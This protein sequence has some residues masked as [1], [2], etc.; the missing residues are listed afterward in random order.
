MFN[1]HQSNFLHDEPQQKVNKVFLGKYLEIERPCLFYFCMDVARKLPD[2]KL[3][4]FFISP[5]GQAI[6]Q[7]IEDKSVEN[8]WN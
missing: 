7:K 6:F 5:R 1:L 3:M 2:L 8:G 4:V